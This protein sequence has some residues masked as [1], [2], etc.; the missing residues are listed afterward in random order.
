MRRALTRAV[1]VSVAVFA[2]LTVPLAVPRD[3]GGSTP[4]DISSLAATKKKKKK[5]QRPPPERAK[6]ATPDQSTEPQATAPPPAAQGAES[7]PLPPERVEADVSTRSVA[8][9]SAFRGTEIV[10]FGSVDY[11][12]QTSAEAG[13]YDVIVV[14]EG[15]PGRVVVRRKNSVAGLWINTAARAFNAVPSYYALASTRPI[16]EIAG[17]ELLAEHVIGFDNIPFRP[18]IEAQMSTL[19]TELRDYQDAITRLKEDEGLFVREDY[20]VAFIGRSLFRSSIELPANIPVG[21]LT[22]RVFLFR[23]GQ[24]LS[25]YTTRVALERKGIELVLYDFAHAWPF[26]Y[27]SL[28]VA[29][30]L[31]CGF[32]ASALFSRQSN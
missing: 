29:L 21:S 22:A 32:A 14:V 1:I 13:Y 4:S 8:V 17:S 15:R 25:K 3:G 9:T 5:P 27:G 31:A 30:A 20:G 12:R 18:S 7:P 2:L 24:L 26:A 19:A 23:D 16:E 11:S 28:A 6:P 10:V